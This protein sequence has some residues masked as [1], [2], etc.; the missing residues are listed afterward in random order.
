MYNKGRKVF[1]IGHK[2]PDTDSICS[3][4]SYAYLKNAMAQREGAL[5]MLAQENAEEL[6]EQETQKEQG[7]QP[8]EAED[9]RKTKQAK[10]SVRY[11][12]CRCGQVNQETAYVLK[13][14][15]I[16]DP[17]LLTDVS[18]QVQDIEIRE[19]HGISEDVSLNTAYRLM[20]EQECV[21]LPV[22][23]RENYLK[24]VI[25]INDIAESD[26]DMY[27][28]RIVGKARTPVKNIVATVDG[29]LLCGNS[30]AYITKGKVIIAASSEAVMNDFLLQDDLVIAA[31]RTKA[32]MCA[33]RNGAACMIVCGP[34]PIKK[35]T[36]AFAEEKEVIVI[37]TAHDTYTTARL[38]NHSMP[39]RRFMSTKN[40][41]AFRLSD[42]VEE[43]QEV[44]ASKRFRD[45][46]I[47]D[48]DGKYVGMISR[49][50]LLG[51]RKKEVILIDHNELSQAVDGADNAEILEIID[52]HRL[53]TIETT[54][55]VYFRCQPLGCTA[56]I[57][58]QLYREQDI[59][60]PAKIAGLLCS[61]IL[62]D[63]LMFRSPTC[64]ALDRAAAECLAKKAGIDIETY[65]REMFKAGS[66]LKNKTAEE[67]F[68]QDFKKF[69]VGDYA[70]GVGQI[71]SMNE[72]DFPQIIKKLAPFM[73]K[74]RE[75]LH[76]SS[77]YFML[78]G[79]LSES[80]DIICC[81]PD[82]VAYAEEAFHGKAKDGVLHLNGVVSRKKQFVPPLV[83]L[84][85]Q[86]NS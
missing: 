43:A 17:L 11:I 32:Q 64:T 38:V 66:N 73:E 4:I 84:L 20:R 52:H 27:D 35:D 30:H 74:E 41:I 31:N 60:I 56:T 69:N 80:S 58:F 44:M 72:A 37:E 9:T 50:N 48:Q 76:V 61:A 21:T 71:N 22:L 39:V 24:G 23:D 57:V 81:G 53:G 6:Q 34:N 63:T 25:T 40:L 19:L 10:A 54:S 67:I 82:A 26:M 8:A 51:L 33:I 68:F 75:A 49:R 28:N 78:T 85:Q 55:P 42:S 79:I 14:F 2:N 47:L 36:L 46:P 18:P 7:T 77:L 15:G 62:S 70:F 45:F 29:K 13:Y 65:A 83:T 1:V 59:E 12:P 3:S 16:E 5:G 86:K